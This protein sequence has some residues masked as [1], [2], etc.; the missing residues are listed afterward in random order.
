MYSNLG[1]TDYDRIADVLFW[2]SKDIT[3]TFVVRL[4][5]Q[6][7]MKHRKFFHREV[8]YPSDYIGT[9]Q[10][11]TIKRD[12]R[13]YFSIDDRNDFANSFLLYSGEVYEL[14]TL[15][16]KGLLPMYFS[17]NKR[18]YEL[19]EDKLV[20]TGEVKPVTY[21]QS[22][23]KYIGFV[24]TVLLEG[25][26]Y[27]EGVRVNFNDVSNYIELSIDRFLDF[28]YILK[29]TDMYSAAC[30]LINYAKIP[31]YGINNFNTSGLGG[32]RDKDVSDSRNSGEDLMDK[33]IE[34]QRNHNKKKGE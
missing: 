20:I 21:V 30:A 3:L 1:F 12:V 16:E 28:Y 24:P 15:I 5:S 11:H 10:N 14:V 2:F 29:N 17:S 7:K 6:D 23:Y 4:S 8:T 27:K 32:S 33:I 19:V 18:I 25:N 26:A 13:Y 34:K 22:E 9:D 31:P